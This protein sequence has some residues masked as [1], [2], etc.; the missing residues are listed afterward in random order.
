MPSIARRWTRTP[1][2]LAAATI[3]VAACAGVSSDPP[4]GACPAVGDYGR[5]EQ[6]RVANEVAALP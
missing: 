1:A 6:A 2:T 4:H 5:A 3:F